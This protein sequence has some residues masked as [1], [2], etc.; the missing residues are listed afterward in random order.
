MKRKILIASILIAAVVSVWGCGNK[1]E[2]KKEASLTKEDFD[3]IELINE[4]SD[5]GMAFFDE[6]ENRGGNYE[7]VFSDDGLVH[8][9]AFA[10]IED[11]AS[12]KISEIDVKGPSHGVFGF[13]VG[14]GVEG[15]EDAL[16]EAGFE[17]IGENTFREDRV[18][19]FKKGNVYVKVYFDK[20]DCIRKI[21]LKVDFEMKYEFPLGVE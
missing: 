4:N 20:G 14:D 5:L 8:G 9:R 13:E 11:G 19:S 12:L 16:K 1:G 21:S 17:Y 7:G 3:T 15:F 10:Y 18:L 2:V 6:R